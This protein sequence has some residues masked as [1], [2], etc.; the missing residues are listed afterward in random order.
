M[1]NE[2]ELCFKSKLNLYTGEKT[3]LNKAVKKAILAACNKVWADNLRKF[4]MNVERNCVIFE[5]W[6][7]LKSEAG[8]ILQH[9]V[10]DTWE[11][12]ITPF[13]NAILDEEI[14]APVFDE[15]V[16]DRAR[17]VAEP[18]LDMLSHTGYRC[19]G[20]ETV[21]QAL[22][23]MYNERH[24]HRNPEVVDISLLDDGDSF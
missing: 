15:W 20:S 22:N 3:M 16:M 8:D 7:E 21:L 12:P 6:D 18:M 17:E 24:P 11:N 1:L 9:N 13:E 14:F 4:G 5:T 19:F 2:S 10:E 23:A